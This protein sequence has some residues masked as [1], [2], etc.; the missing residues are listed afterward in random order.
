MET[1]HKL[2][3]DKKTGREAPMEIGSRCIR[4]SA[5]WI[6]LFGCELK[7]KV[8]PIR[9]WGKYSLIDDERVRHNYRSIV[10]TFRNARR[11]HVGI[12]YK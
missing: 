6:K 3:D 12:S 5:N 9:S 8:P 11:A 7:L 10:P 4:L 1:L 2:E